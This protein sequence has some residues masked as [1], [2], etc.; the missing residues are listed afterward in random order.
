MGLKPFFPPNGRPQKWRVCGN[1]E[2]EWAQPNSKMSFPSN[3]SESMVHYELRISPNQVSVHKVF[4]RGNVKTLLQLVTESS[5][6]KGK[7]IVYVYD[8]KRKNLLVCT[9]ERLIDT[10]A[11][12][13]LQETYISSKPVELTSKQ[14]G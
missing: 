10:S 5:F 9:V 1:D 14:E 12:R 8:K 2:I 4:V 13:T 7:N 3:S 11:I 6:P